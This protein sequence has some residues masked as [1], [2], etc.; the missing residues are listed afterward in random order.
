MT[1]LKRSYFKSKDINFPLLFPK[2]Q[3][4]QNEFILTLKQTLLC[5]MFILNNLPICR[6]SKETRIPR[7]S[8]ET[9]A[10][11]GWPKGAACC[12]PATEEAWGWGPIVAC[13]DAAAPAEEP[14]WSGKCWSW[15]RSDKTDL[16]HHIPCTTEGLLTWW[17]EF[18]SFYFRLF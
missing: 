8:G 3:H 4:F 15:W 10:A 11:S 18:W 2:W 1:P 7:P 16:W 9:A 14:G 6:C 17:A 13:C 12:G 5:Q